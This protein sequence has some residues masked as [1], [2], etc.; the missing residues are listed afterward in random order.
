MAMLAVVE[1]T[2]EEG[3]RGW[4]D[5]TDGNNDNGEI[6][7]QFGDIIVF[8]GT[9]GSYS[10]QNHC[11]IIDPEMVRLSYRRCKDQIKAEKSGTASV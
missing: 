1:A 8:G 2:E 4:G 5:T 11:Y 10:A 6:G 9:D 7:G 3:D